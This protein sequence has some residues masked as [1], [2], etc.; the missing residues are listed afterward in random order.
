M[1]IIV[2]LARS[3]KSYVEAFE[4]DDFGNNFWSLRNPLQTNVTN[5]QL[6]QMRAK[7]ISHWVD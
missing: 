6:R 2:V 7:K 5:W 1:M 3:I 4:M